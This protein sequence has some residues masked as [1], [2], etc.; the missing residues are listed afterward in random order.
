MWSKIKRRSWRKPRWDAVCQDDERVDPTC[1]LLPFVGPAQTLQF[2]RYVTHIDTTFFYYTIPNPLPL[3]QVKGVDHTDESGKSV[4]LRLDPRMH[5]AH[6][7]V[8]GGTPYTEIRSYDPQGTLM[9]R[10]PRRACHPTLL[11]FQKK[12]EHQSPPE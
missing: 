5:T 12:S 1:T 4:A 7:I 6:H 9:W 3:S 2:Q 8:V 11:V 10:M